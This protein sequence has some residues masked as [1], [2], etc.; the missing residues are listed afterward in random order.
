MSLKNFTAD[1]KPGTPLFRAMRIGSTIRFDS[2]TLREASPSHIT[3]DLNDNSGTERI[4]RSHPGLWSDS[5]EGAYA[6]LAKRE[7]PAPPERAEKKRPDLAEVLRR[8]ASVMGMLLPAL[9]AS[10]TTH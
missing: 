7:R 6:N 3:L 1:P 8:A 5:P 9:P 2:A 4:P 10:P